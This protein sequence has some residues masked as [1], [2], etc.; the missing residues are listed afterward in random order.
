MDLKV[1]DGVLGYR[2]SGD[3]QQSALLFP[4][5]VSLLSSSNKGPAQTGGNTEETPVLVWD[6]RECKADLVPCLKVVGEGFLQ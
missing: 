5:K 1:P 2:M 4:A 6:R 3:Q